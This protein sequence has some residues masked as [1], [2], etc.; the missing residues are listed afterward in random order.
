[1]DPVT[2][3]KQAVDEVL[4]V[5]RRF[6]RP[7]ARALAQ[8][9]T[10]ELEDGRSLPD[11]LHLQQLAARALERRWHRLHSADEARHDALAYRHAV[12]ARRD[13]Q[14]SLLY[15]E[16]VDLRSVLRGRFGAARSRN[17]IGLRGHTSRDPM[18]ILTQADRAV[19]R[20]RDPGRPLP[21]SRLPVSDAARER[22]AVPVAETADAMRVIARHVVTA[23]K[24]A[25]LARRERKLALAEFNRVFVLLAGWFESLYRLAGRDDWAELVRPSKQ[26]PGLTWKQGKSR[27][28]RPAK[29][30]SGSKLARFP[31]L[32]PVLRIFGS[33]A[34][35]SGP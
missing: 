24:N 27:H 7:T 30:Q 17:F 18:A 8:L 19:S 4:S 26:Y 9:L 21:H 15:R 22:W 1:M 10:P 23:I 29:A 5:H 20:L 34:R 3:R 2:D 6:A 12:I 31:R 35:S 11:L 16:I 28:R 14:V 13:E 25:D 33:R 32:E